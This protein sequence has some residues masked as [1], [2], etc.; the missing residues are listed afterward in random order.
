MA[1]YQ[2]EMGTV[3]HRDENGRLQETVYYQKA[4]KTWQDG[5]AVQVFGD[6]NGTKLYNHAKLNELVH[7]L[8]TEQLGYFF[9]LVLNVNRKGEICRYDS[10]ARRLIPLRSERE[11]QDYLGMSKSSWYR[12]RSILKERRIYQEISHCTGKRYLLNPVYAV[13]SHSLMTEEMAFA[14]RY[15]VYPYL[16]PRKQELVA[17]VFG[18]T[19]APAEIAADDEIV[20][21]PPTEGVLKSQDLLRDMEQQLQLEKEVIDQFLSSVD[22]DMVHSQRAVRWMSDYMDDIIGA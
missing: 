22:W 19:L 7:A 17:N 8:S 13:E 9:R 18:E 2:Y 12:F 1:M 3:D 20:M 11:I 5:D 14:F 4:T 21:T 6:K 10:S 16:S 15:D